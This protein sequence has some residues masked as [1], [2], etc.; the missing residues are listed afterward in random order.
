MYKRIAALGLA[1][2]FVLSFTACGSMPYDD[3]D[4]EDYITVGDYKG[5]E[6]E[7]Y[8]IEVTD[9]EVQA[10]VEWI[11]MSTRRAGRRS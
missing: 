7:K 3:Y 6:V 4:L 5:L 1:L 11:R 2:V 8:T 10:R 9:D